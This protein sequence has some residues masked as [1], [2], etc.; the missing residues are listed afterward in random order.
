MVPQQWTVDSYNLFHLFC[1]MEGMLAMNILCADSETNM[2]VLNLVHC[3]ANGSG[4]LHYVSEE[5]QVADWDEVHVESPPLPADPKEQQSLP[6]I[7]TTLEL[8]DDTAAMKKKDT[9]FQLPVSEKGSTLYSRKESERVNT[10]NILGMQPEFKEPYPES[11][12]TIVE[13]V[14]DVGL[15]LGPQFQARLRMERTSGSPDS[16]GTQSLIED[17][18]IPDILPSESSTNSSVNLDSSTSLDGLS[19]S[20]SDGGI[21]AESL[22]V[23]PEASVSNQRSNVNVQSGSDHPKEKRVSLDDAISLLET[24]MSP[25]AGTPIEEKLEA[26]ESPLGE[27]IDRI[28]LLDDRFQYVQPPHAHQVRHVGISRRSVVVSLRP[29]SIETRCTH[30]THSSGAL[31]GGAGVP[32]SH[33]PPSTVYRHSLYSIPM[34]IDIEN[35]NSSVFGH[36]SRFENW[37]SEVAMSYTLNMASIVVYGRTSGIQKSAL[38]GVRRGGGEE[39]YGLM[40]LSEFANEGSV[41]KCGEFRGIPA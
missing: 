27:A 21:L 20:K 33:V 28:G 15:H 13:E 19:N 6:R 22:N 38:E 5:A 34:T 31:S 39:L 14:Q 18:S 41:S 1:R 32:G 26:L 29:R 17:E 2:N 25:V 40:Q 30:Y 16:I 3:L 37:P 10:L 11:P 12:A 36:A 23:K 24:R 4:K 8:P 35:E 7:E 9:R